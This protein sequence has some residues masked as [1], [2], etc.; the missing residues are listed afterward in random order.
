MT[1]YTICSTHALG[2]ANAHKLFHN[3]KGNCIVNIRTY[4]FIL[5]KDNPYNLATNTASGPSKS[6]E[7]ESEYEDMKTGNEEIPDKPSPAENFGLL[8]N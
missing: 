1:R 3:D 6:K 4:N 7:L 8:A 5:S 2:A